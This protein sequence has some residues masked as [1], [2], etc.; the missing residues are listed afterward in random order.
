VAYQRKT[1]LEYAKWL[2]VLRGQIYIER[3]AGF[4]G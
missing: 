4:G 3:R 2:E 1:E